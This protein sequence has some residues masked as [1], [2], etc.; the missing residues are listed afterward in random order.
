MGKT[1]AYNMFSEGLFLFTV[2]GTS[3]KPTFLHARWEIK[4]LTSQEYKI[5]LAVN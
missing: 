4:L 5:Y 2:S 1:L 3:T